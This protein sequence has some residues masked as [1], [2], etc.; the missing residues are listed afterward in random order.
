MDMKVTKHTVCLVPCGSERG[1]AKESDDKQT[2]LVQ[3]NSEWVLI[4]L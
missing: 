1:K 4:G 3:D 2:V